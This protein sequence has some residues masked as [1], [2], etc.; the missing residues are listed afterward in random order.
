[1]LLSLHYKFLW[2]SLGPAVVF[3]VSKAFVRKE[4]E[5]TVVKNVN[6]IKKVNALFITPNE[7]PKEIEIPNT[8]RTYKDLIHGPISKICLEQE[9]DDRSKVSLLYTASDDIRFSANRYLKDYGI[10]CS[11]IIIIG[12]AKNGKYKSLTKDQVEKYQDVFGEESIKQLNAKIRARV[13]ARR[14]L[15]R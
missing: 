11:N 10:I 6:K 5:M 15:R 4:E 8:S 2:C 12:E 13:L 3:A 7:I 9:N 1:M 14:F